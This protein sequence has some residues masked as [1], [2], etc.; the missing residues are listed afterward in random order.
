MMSGFNRKHE[1]GQDH[2]LEL[3]VIRGTS[4]KRYSVSGGPFTM[5][6]DDVLDGSPIHELTLADFRMA[7]YPVTNGQVGCLSDG[8][9]WF[10][11]HN[12]MLGNQ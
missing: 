2:C 4:T 7:K 11:G 6:G 9:G 8:I 3:W 12:G 10:A 1:R 5:G